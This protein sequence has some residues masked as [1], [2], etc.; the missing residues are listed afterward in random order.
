MTNIIIGFNGIEKSKVSSLLQNKIPEFD[1]VDD[2]TDVQETVAKN[3]NIVFA[4]VKSSE[5]SDLIVAKKGFMV[6]LYHDHSV[7]QTTRSATDPT[8]VMIQSL[9]ETVDPAPEKSR[10]P[11]II[12]I[13]GLAGAGKSTMASILQ[14]E[15]GFIEYAFANPLKEACK[16]LFG[17]NKEQLYGDQKE[18]EDPTWKVTPRY[19][20]QRFGTEIIRQHLFKELPKL[21]H[22]SSS[23]FIELAQKFINSHMESNIIFSDV[24]FEDEALLVV[25]N[26]GILFRIVRDSCVADTHSSARAKLEGPYEEIVILNNGTLEQ[27]QST[28]LSHLQR[29][30]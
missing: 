1:L 9:F 17:L 11:M 30:Q 12:G 13:Q 20:L 18:V 15:L 4:Q 7:I 29:F 21:H 2:D 10:K 16:A 28:I 5:L 19:I 26:G 25:E 14:R 24:R 23:L 22:E 3:K 8:Y 27:F 6:Y